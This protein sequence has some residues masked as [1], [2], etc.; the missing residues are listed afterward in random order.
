MINF[1]VFRAGLQHFRQAQTLKNSS[2][3]IT[4][5]RFGQ[6][7]ISLSLSAGPGTICQRRNTLAKLAVLDP[8]DAQIDE[9]NRQD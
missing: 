8:L 6:Q 4:R 9:G 7:D 5:G 1:S 2:W 3:V